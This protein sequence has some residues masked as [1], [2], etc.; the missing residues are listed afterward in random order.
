M[1]DVHCPSKQLSHV[2]N[3]ITVS[4]ANIDDVASSERI[5]HGQAEGARDVSHM[6]EVPFLLAVF[7][8]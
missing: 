7:E 1:W 6:H 2:L 5:I 3:R 4:A 8:D